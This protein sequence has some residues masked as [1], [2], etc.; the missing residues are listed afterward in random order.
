VNVYS[1]NSEG[2][3]GFVLRFIVFKKPVQFYGN[4]LTVLLAVFFNIFQHYSMRFAS[5]V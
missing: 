4:L 1:D 5:S 3:I 2:N